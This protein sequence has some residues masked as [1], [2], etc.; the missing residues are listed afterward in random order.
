MMGLTVRLI[1]WTCFCPSHTWLTAAGGWHLLISIELQWCS[2]VTHQNK[3]ILHPICHIEYI[4]SCQKTPYGKIA[5]SLNT[6]SFPTVIPLSRLNAYDLITN[7]K[8]FIGWIV[9]WMLGALWKLLLMHST[10]SISGQPLD[11][12]VAGQKKDIFSINLCFSRVEQLLWLKLWSV[13]K[14]A[15]L[16]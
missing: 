15:A 4:I 2:Q 14:V 10:A 7:Y 9:R 8:C 5:D 12:R 3:D 6:P 1:S 11:I 13:Q 16:G